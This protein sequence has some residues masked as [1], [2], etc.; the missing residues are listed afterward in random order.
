MVYARDTSLPCGFL[1]VCGLHWSLSGRAESP[2]EHPPGA[3]VASGEPVRPVGAVVPGAQDPGGERPDQER[4]DDAGGG[5]ASGGSDTAT[6]GPFLPE[7][8]WPRLRGAQAGVRGRACLSRL[9]MTAEG[10]SLGGGH[11]PT[12]QCLGHVQLQATRLG[13]YSLTG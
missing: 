7:A 1:D 3:G 9:P 8:S 2:Q 11:A 5:A 4:Q 10:L 6:P 12:P 13:R